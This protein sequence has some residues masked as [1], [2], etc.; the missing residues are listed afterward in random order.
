MIK[1]VNNISYCYL[2]KYFE[3]SLA[4]IRNILGVGNMEI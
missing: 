2:R 3:N 1:H 4:K